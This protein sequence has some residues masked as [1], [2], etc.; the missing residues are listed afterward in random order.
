MGGSRLGERN[1]RRTS[2]ADEDRQ[3]ARELDPT[4]YLEACG[5]SVKREG[6]HLSIR[7]N[8][9]E[10]YRINQKP[11]GH[12]LWC[13]RYGNHGGDNI[14]LVQEIEPSI[15][16]AEAVYR[17][18]GEPMVN[19]QPRRAQRKRQP[20]RLPAQAVANQLSGR[21]YLG[22]ERGIS[23]DTLDHAEACGMLCY[24]EGGVLFVGYDNAGTVQNITRRAISP[25]E[26][27]QKRD[28]RGSDKSF[29]P[30]LSG[31]PDIIWVVEGGVDALALRDLYKRRGEQPP[32]VLMLISG[33]A[34]VR[35]FLERPAMQSILKQAKRVVIAHEN[36]KDAAT[37]QRTDAAHQKQVQRV[38]EITGRAVKSW[39][40]K[41]D[42]GN[43]LAD[44]NSRQQHK[45]KP[46]QL[47]SQNQQAGVKPSRLLI[48]GDYM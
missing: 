9:D 11:D 20:P 21:A 39:K 44:M 27:V 42:Q 41:P 48:D 25:A 6:P 40:P 22:N 19:P 31:S 38:A 7:D 45:M 43:D 33:G 17:L 35:S 36:E 23:N 5:Y 34:N 1:A 3:S 47:M 30:I 4:S 37:Q 46:V 15:S 28:L 8:D 14:D 24:A 26:P 29:P 18:A 10:V 32:T 12:W 16:F 2:V 13:D